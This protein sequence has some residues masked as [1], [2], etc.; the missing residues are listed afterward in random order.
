MAESRVKWIGSI[1]RKV[2]MWSGMTKL[3]VAEPGKVNH[4][5]G[6]RFDS[7]GGS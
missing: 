5:T 7:D 4:S 1:C 3:R 6:L 2:M